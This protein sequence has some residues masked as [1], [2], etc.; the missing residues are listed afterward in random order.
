VDSDPVASV[1][2]YVSDP[3][4]LPV[5]TMKTAEP[6]F[7][8]CGLAVT[9]EVFDDPPLLW[10]FTEYV[11]AAVALLFRLS[12]TLTTPAAVAVLSGGREGGEKVQ[13]RWSAPPAVHTAVAL[14]LDTLVLENV[15]W[16]PAYAP[17]LLNTKVALPADVVGALR[18]TAGPPP[19][20]VHE[21]E[22]SVG[23]IVRPVSDVTRLPF[24]SWI[25][26]TIW[27]QLRS[28]F[29]VPG[30]QPAWTAAGC[31]ES[32][33]RTAMRLGAPTIWVVSV[34]L[35][36]A[37][38]ELFVVTKTRQLPGVLVAVN[39]TA[40]RPCATV[41]V[42]LP[43]E[44][45]PVPVV[46]PVMVQTFTLPASRVSVRMVELS[47]P[48]RFPCESVTSTCR[49]VVDELSAAI[50]FVRKVPMVFVAAPGPVLVTMTLQPVSPLAEADSWIS[51]GVAVLVMVTV[52]T[53]FAGET[54][55]VGV[56]DARV[57]VTFTT[58][59]DGELA[60]DTV[61]PFA[62]LSVIFAIEMPADVLP[63][64]ATIGDGLAVQPSWVALP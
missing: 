3:T 44:P 50:G 54:T 63:L 17:R 2:V 48:I 53:P 6:P 58:L 23:V 33:L 12:R 43:P 56:I 25:P 57:G 59:I 39:V 61:F 55:P 40:I 10:K 37:I 20:P 1:G 42:A 4:M 15:I 16:Q 28:A 64:L 60:F 8:F 27:V 22:S 7:V 45:E 26:T 38:D 29:P 11:P 14:T 34:T 46:T 35:V 41:T 52:A 9:T 32:L 49:L 13:D 19:A 51:P 30:A 47:V 36:P 24:T 5:L 18:E 62:S 21:P 31:G